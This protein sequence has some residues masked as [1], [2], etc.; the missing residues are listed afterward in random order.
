ME[1]GYIVEMPLDP[2]MQGVRQALVATYRPADADA[3]DDLIARLDEV[4]GEPD[5]P[6]N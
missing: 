4:T 2:M 5:Q 3:F 6:C 1:N